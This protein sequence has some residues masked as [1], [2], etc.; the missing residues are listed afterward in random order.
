MIPEGEVRARFVRFQRWTIEVE[1]PARARFLEGPVLEAFSDYYRKLP[2]SAD[3]AAIRHWLRGTWRGD[4]GWVA[5]W[6]GRRENPTVLDAGSGFGT[7][8]ML[9]AAVGADV[10]AVDLR[11]DRLEGAERRLAFYRESTDGTLRMRNRREPATVRPVRHS[12]WFRPF[13]PRSTDRTRT[14]P[15]RSRTGLRGR[16]ALRERRVRSRG[17][18]R[19]PLCAR[20]AR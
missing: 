14:R 2:A 9:Y 8:A 18:L 10:T 5:R 6:L 12:L 17:Q 20:R 4:S 11:P 7:F 3:Q 19:R 16:C 1:Y 13:P 15:P